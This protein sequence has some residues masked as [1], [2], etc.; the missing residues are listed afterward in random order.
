MPFTRPEGLTAK[1]AEDAKIGR[2]IDEKPSAPACPPWRFGVLGAP[3]KAGEMS[4]R[5]EPHE[6]GVATHLD[7]ESCTATREGTVKR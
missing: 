1:Y 4:W 7:P 6:E 5:K 3:A 2:L